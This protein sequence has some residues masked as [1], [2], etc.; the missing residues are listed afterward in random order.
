MSSI[1]SRSPAGD[2]YPPNAGWAAHLIDQP[3][4]PVLSRVPVVGIA[5]EVGTNVSFEVRPG[6]GRWSDEA[7]HR[8]MELKAPAE[9]VSVHH[10]VEMQIAAWMVRSCT[11]R[12]ELVINREPCGER[13]GLGCHQALP[14]FLPVGYRMSVSGTRGG[15]RYYSYSYDG[16]ANS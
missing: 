9:F 14:I 3:Y 11:R 15:S 16:R 8:F 10:H 12:T 5:R 7:E 6:Q 13:F 1:P 2:A 4:S